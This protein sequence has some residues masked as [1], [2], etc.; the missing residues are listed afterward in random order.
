M[1][2]PPESDT[3]DSW[4]ETRRTLGWRRYEA[5]SGCAV[6]R[7]AGL[8]DGVSSSNIVTGIELVSEANFEGVSK[9]PTEESEFP[10]RWVLHM[11]DM[12]SILVGGE[13]AMSASIEGPL[14]KSEFRRRDCGELGTEEDAN[15]IGWSDTTDHRWEG[16]PAGMGGAEVTEALL[17][18]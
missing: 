16:G 1:S 11:G 4:D 2:R 7:P 18:Q 5:L 9:P 15:S 17:E 8:S 14:S 10:E 13:D 3:M 12:G 6:P